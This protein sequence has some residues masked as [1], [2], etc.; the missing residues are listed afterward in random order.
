M[1]SKGT[2]RTAFKT[3]RVYGA[4]GEPRRLARPRSV[5]GPTKPAGWSVGR[6]ALRILAAGNRGSKALI[7]PPMQECDLRSLASTRFAVHALFARDKEITKRASWSFLVLFSSRHPLTT[8]KPMA[9]VWPAV[10]I[11]YLGLSVFHAALLRRWDP[12]ARSSLKFVSSRPSFI[13]I[14][15]NVR[16]VCWDYSSRYVQPA[17][18]TLLQ[19][20]VDRT[21]MFNDMELLR[22]LKLGFFFKIEDRQKD[23]R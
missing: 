15:Q 2:R 13:G 11:S 3:A 4:P 22:P 17:R 21:W 7:I 1:M 18:G 12:T 23:S 5:P 19:I 9:F 14:H 6:S 8:R 10:C 20:N 16:A